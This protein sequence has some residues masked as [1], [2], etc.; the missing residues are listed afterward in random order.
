MWPVLTGLGGSVGIGGGA[1]TLSKRCK[2]TFSGM[3][4]NE[5]L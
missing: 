5:Q 3:Q 2:T 4:A 1:G